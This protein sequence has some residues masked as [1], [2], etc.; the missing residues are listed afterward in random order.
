[1][2]ILLVFAFVAA[3]C[4]GGSEEADRRAEA[5][6]EATTADG[7]TPDPTTSS[8]ADTTSTAPAAVNEPEAEPQLLSPGAVWTEVT[9]PE[10]TGP[11]Q[12]VVVGDEV[13]SLGQRFNAPLVNRSDDGITWDRVDVQAPPTSGTAT[14]DGLVRGPDGRYVGFG[15]RTSTCQTA[16]PLGDGYLYVG[17]CKERRALIHVSDDGVSWRQITPA[18]MAPPGDSSVK[19]QSIIVDPA[20]GYLVAGTIRG[21]DWFTR[22]WRSDDGENWSVVRDVRGADGPI[23]PTQLLSDGETV[24]LLANEHPCMTPSRSTP[25][26][27]LASRWP[28][29][30]RI[31]VRAD[32]GSFELQTTSDLELAWAPM[33]VD[34]AT[35]ND[36]F[37]LADARYA[38]AVGEVVGETITLLDT[39]VALEEE[40]AAS[41]DDVEDPLTATRTFSRLV[42]DA[43]T[44]VT[45]DGLS[46]EGAQSE[47]IVD[48]DGEIGL[49]G[50]RRVVGD[51][52]VGLASVL[53]DGTDAWIE[54]VSLDPVIGEW[55]WVRGAVWFGDALLARG[56]TVADP[57]TSYRP[58]D[59]PLFGKIWRSVAILDRDLPVCDLGPGARCRFVDFSAQPGY[60]DLV[61]LDLTGA[62]LLYPSLGGADYSGTLF[63]DATLVGASSSFAE[64]TGA[65]FAGADLRGAGIRDAGGAD[66]SGADLTSATL[67]FSTRPGSLEGAKLAG[68]TLEVVRD[69]TLEFATLELSLAGFDLTLAR[70]IGPRED[71]IFLVITD[72]RGA[73]LDR[74]NL[75]NVDLS[76]ANVDGVDLA[77]FD[78][79]GDSICPDGLPQD[80]SPF[81]TCV[82]E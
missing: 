58:P 52:L 31:F 51:G 55:R 36:N 35:A 4:A 48:V 21:A 20:G 70:I 24:V 72:L 25:G 77:S 15:V 81:G 64:F 69:E 68:A 50:I 42:A 54:T 46:V 2:A 76:G 8:G 28:D 12:L 44:T 53:P 56:Q 78:V 39:T 34:C 11:G 1:V 13:W 66:F 82:R 23:S 17:I 6:V 41:D 60:P 26:W 62:E 43:W 29:H 57:F 67:E 79:L 7:A 65:S 37:D 16:D 14:F 73:I 38:S 19:L 80:G 9:D 63:V 75:Q 61:D 71:G 40:G 47:L 5:P 10:E 33:E 27:V 49:V 59:D 74:A 45:I 18:A 3:A 22:L 32:N 30:L